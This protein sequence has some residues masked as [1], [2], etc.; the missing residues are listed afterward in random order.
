MATASFRRVYVYLQT[1]SID[2]VLGA[3]AGMLFFARLVGAELNIILYVL[4][5]LA[6]W[7]IYTFDH[8]LDARQIGS[9]ASTFRHAFHQ[10]HFKALSILLV[11]MGCLGLILALIMLRIKYII[12]LGLGLGALILLVFILFKVRPR[13]WAF[14]KEIFIATLYVGGIMLAPFFHRE[15]QLVPADF[16]W[17]GSAYV[18]VAWFNSAYLGILDRETDQKDGLYSLALRLGE[19]K[20]RKILRIILILML[21]YI[22]SFYLWL[23][24]FTYMHISILLLIA[25]V[26][27]IAFLERDRHKD[28]IRR[29]LD[30][31][32]M[33]P[34]LLLLL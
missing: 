31:S 22:A 13:Q 14:L 33:L 5:G 18:L 11:V 30:G 7:C 25:L 24:S 9:Q 29:K 2:I 26:H 32:F 20:S 15:S 17:L 23:G 19:P 12:G 6:V 16:W 4:L 8:L 27:A 3:C 21:G 10:R 1:L 28:A 34:F